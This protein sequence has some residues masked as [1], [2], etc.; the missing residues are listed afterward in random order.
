MFYYP[1]NGNIYDNTQELYNM[2]DKID[3]TI[4]MREQYNQRQ[5]PGTVNQTF[6]ITPNQSAPQNDSEFDVKYV[7]NE[8]E[9]KNALIF[10][11]TMFLNKE[12]NIL[13]I[14]QVKGGVKT[15]SLTEIIPIDPKDKEIMDLR[16][17]NRI[18]KEAMRN[19]KSNDDAQ[20]N[21][22]FNEYSKNGKP[23]KIQR[24]KPDDANESRS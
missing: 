14:K 6:Q 16:E 15:F 11:D 7:Q 17:E 13:W 2:R 3:Q 12:F 10:K 5:M 1:N 23:A 24:D 20:P 21:G 8:D 9:M 22:K 19:V 18:L 4:K